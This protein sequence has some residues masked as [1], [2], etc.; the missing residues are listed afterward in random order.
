MLIRL[1]RADEYG[2]AEFQPGQEEVDE[3][4]IVASTSIAAPATTATAA[5]AVVIPATDATSSEG[6][7]LLQKGLFLAVILGCVAV[8]L[9]MGNKKHNRYDEKNMA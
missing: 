6:F 2:H 8:Y 3:I 1:A 9:R 5:P 7:T 4:P